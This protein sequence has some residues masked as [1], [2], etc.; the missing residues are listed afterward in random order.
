VG[1][2]DRQIRGFHGTGPGA[3]IH[4]ALPEGHGDKSPSNRHAIRWRASRIAVSQMQELFQSD[5]F[6]D[7]NQLLLLLG[8][9]AE[10]FFQPREKRPLY[11]EP[12]LR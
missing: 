4:A 8:Q 1:P 10:F 11:I 6:Q 9:F 7:G 5:H 2:P 12:I 3:A